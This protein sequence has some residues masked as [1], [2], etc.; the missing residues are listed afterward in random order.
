[1]TASS[2]DTKPAAAAWA[3]GVG[4]RLGVELEGGVAARRQQRAAGAAAA[5]T[6]TAAAAVKAVAIPLKY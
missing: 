3:A 5:T 6:T 2:C 1:M 4:W